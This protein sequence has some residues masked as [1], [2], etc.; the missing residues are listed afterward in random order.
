MRVK[1]PALQFYPGDW[2]R[3]DVSGCSLAAQGL[4]L[5]MI[6]LMHDSERYGYLATNGT[7]I[8]PEHIARR[9]GVSQD[10]YVALLAELDAM[11]IFSRTTEGVIY[12]RRMVRDFAKRQALSAAGKLGGNPRLKGLVNQ[13][14]KAGDKPPLKKKTED[15]RETEELLAE[16]TE[17]IYQ[18][19]PRKVAKPEALKAIRRQMESGG[20][21]PAF[22][23]QRTMAF[24]DAVQKW[25]EDE[26]QFIPHPATWFNQQRFN[27]DEK[28][29]QR[30][31]VNAT[32]RTDNARFKSAA[33]DFDNI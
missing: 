23:L 22:L 28:T 14:V 27:D 20:F 13:E 21:T 5:R 19:Y 4:W 6:F 31:S 18:Q 10:Q 24:F 12:S 26:K 32:N 29:W 17:K 11:R 8:P 1:L 25:S 7:P 15:E 30:R 33:G 3:D 16:A 9:C 2:L